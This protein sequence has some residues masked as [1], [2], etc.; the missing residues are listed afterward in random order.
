L[1]EMVNAFIDIS[2]K[3]QDKHIELYL[4]GPI[5][6]NDKTEIIEI[7]RQAGYNKNL[8]IT[9]RIPHVDVKK[10]LS[11]ADIGFSI[12]YPEPNFLKSLATKLFEYMEAGIPYIASNFEYWDQ[13]TKSEKCGISV[14]PRNQIE[15]NR[16][17]HLL[18][19][20]KELRTRLG[21]SGLKASVKYTWSNEEKKLLDV[22]NRL[23]SKA[24]G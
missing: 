1:N 13:I 21:E 16:A 10:Y 24:R 5:S 17:L 22:Y 12:L 23:I 15:I 18:V 19:K 3:C 7:A 14:D 9:G 6:E 4:I 11:I 2:M 8:Y 20:N